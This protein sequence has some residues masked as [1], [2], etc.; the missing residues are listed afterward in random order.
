MHLLFPLKQYSCNQETLKKI[1]KIICALTLLIACLQNVKIFDF[2]GSTSFKLYHIIVLFSF[3][4][5]LARRRKEWMCP[6]P[7]MLVF[8]YIALIGCINIFSFGF[9]TLN[10]GYVYMFLVLLTVF[11][12]LNSLETS[13]IDKTLQNTA[14]AFLGLVLIK[15]FLYSGNV[16]L[17]YVNANWHPMI[18]TFIGG[19]VN[20]E[21]TWIA[22]FT[23]FF[24]RDIK[25][26]LY[27]FV[28]CLVCMIYTSR[29]GLITF[30]L[31]AFYVLVFKAPQKKNVISFKIASFVIV[32]LIVI[33]CLM[34]MGVSILER[35]IPS[36]NDDGANGRLAMWVHILDAF[37][38]SPIFGNGAGNTINVIEA[39]S[40]ISF[41]EDNVHNLYAQVLLDFGSVGL[42][43][44]LFLIF[45]FIKG[46][47]ISR[48]VTSADMALLC[49]LVASSF[50]FRGGDVLIG[51]MIGLA[52][53]HRIASSKSHPVLYYGYRILSVSKNKSS[54]HSCGC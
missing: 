14:L 15:L 48:N 35:F 9:N 11:N 37:N 13:E 12:L 18:P 45:T 4:Y 1:D 2:V 20:I 42:I 24:N 39:V 53:C 22:L 17:V 47:F 44:Y 50:Q 49:L 34:I 6:T 8:C 29:T 36:A 43:I 7:V 41:T 5:S 38:V 28:S 23:V 40:R 52:M 27:I 51:F 16:G 54:H 30:A 31:A 21:A 46:L 25:G 3:L 10:V 26:F 33:V 19:G 32:G